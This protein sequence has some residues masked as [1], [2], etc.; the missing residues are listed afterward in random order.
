MANR[1]D[2][3]TVVVCFLSPRLPVLPSPGR[4]EA[5]I[6]YPSIYRS[7]TDGLHNIAVGDAPL[8]I[9][10]YRHR[11]ISETVPCIEWRPVVCSDRFT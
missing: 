10:I 1:I 3:S 2:N 6:P 8:L 4:R 7:K 5:P 9:H 11:K